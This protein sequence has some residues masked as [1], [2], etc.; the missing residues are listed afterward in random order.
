LSDFQGLP[1]SGEVAADKQVEHSEIPL[2]GERC[3]FAIVVYAERHLTQ[4]EDPACGAGRCGEIGNPVRFQI[5]ELTI[6][7]I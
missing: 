1:A 2:C 4:F 6:S 3:C 7:K 5:I